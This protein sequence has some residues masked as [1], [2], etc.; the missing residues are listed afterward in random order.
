MRRYSIHSE[1]AANCLTQVKFAIA[2][3]AAFLDVHASRRLASVLLFSS[4]F[5][6]VAPNLHPE[7]TVSPIQSV[8]AL[9]MNFE[10][11][12]G[13]ADAQVKFLSRGGGYSLFLTA[14]E[15]VLALRRGKSRT[16]SQRSG[17]PT[18]VRMKLVDANHEPAIEA[19]DE[20]AQ[21]RLALPGAEHLI[22]R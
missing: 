11:N 3:F 21:R 5:F 9:P 1:R 17:I 20:L 19:A 7:T 14:N 4:L 6:L 22:Q 2:F 10:P 8:A 18:V 15:A 13:Q 12:R 16:K